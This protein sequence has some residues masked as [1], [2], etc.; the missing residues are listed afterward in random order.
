MLS[1]TLPEKAIA[2]ADEATVITQR[3]TSS[4]MQLE[5]TGRYTTTGEMSLELLWAAMRE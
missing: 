1:V 5:Q 4:A 2:N 3:A